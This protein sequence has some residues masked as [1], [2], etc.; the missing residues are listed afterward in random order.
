[1][2][3]LNVFII[4]C[5]LFLLCIADRYRWIKRNKDSGLPYYYYGVWGRI[6]AV[7]VHLCLLG[8]IVVFAFKW[9]I[10]ILKYSF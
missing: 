9:I 6:Y 10:A 2:T 4:I 5:L 8:V 7:S 1:M 3:T